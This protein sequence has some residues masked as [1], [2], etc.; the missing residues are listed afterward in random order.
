M[1]NFIENLI[2]FSVIHYNPPVL[3]IKIILYF[4]K[5]VLYGGTART[6]WLSSAKESK[7]V[8]H[9]MSYHCRLTGLGML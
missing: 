6:M 2:L 1:K 9:N 3:N 7:F 4:R 5:Y 8:S